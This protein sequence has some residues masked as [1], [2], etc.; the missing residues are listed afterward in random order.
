VRKDDEDDMEITAPRRAV[1]VTDTAPQPESSGWRPQIETG[2]ILGGLLAL[3]LFLPHTLFGDGEKRYLELAQLLDGHGF[4]TYKYSL[5]GPLFSAPLWYLGAPFRDAA[6]ALA[7][8]LSARDASWPV[9]AITLL[10]LAFS[11]WVGINGAVY[12]QAPLLPY[13]YGPNSPYATTCQ[14]LPQTS[15]LWSPLVTGIRLGWKSWLWIAYSLLVF[16]YLA[17]PLA[18]SLLAEIWRAARSLRMLHLADAL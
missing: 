9:R 15:V 12:D 14:Y 10:L 11:V 4:S 3:A 5:I 1:Q 6:F 2:L 13:C 17:Y 7:V 8:W 16:G 18:R